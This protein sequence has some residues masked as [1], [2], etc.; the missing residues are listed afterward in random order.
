MSLAVSPRKSVSKMPVCEIAVTLDAPRRREGLDPLIN[1]VTIAVCAVVCGADDFVAL[2]AWG[3]TKQPWLAKFLD[4]SR[5]IPSH[6]RFNAIF[7]A[8]KP[9]EFEKCL[10]S[11]ITSLHEISDG[12]IDGIKAFFLRAIANGFGRFTISRHGMTIQQH[13]HRLGLELHRE[14]PT[15]ERSTCHNPQCRLRQKLHP[16]AQLISANR[17]SRRVGE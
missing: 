2:A 15:L 17:I 11:S 16:N 1:V 4:V 14:P 5:G 13:L 12:Q 10:P 7:A 6:D 8:I 9:A 3:H